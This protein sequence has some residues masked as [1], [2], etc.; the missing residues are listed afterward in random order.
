MQSDEPLSGFSTTVLC[1]F[2]HEL[3]PY[4]Y[5][6][7]LA[8]EGLPDLLRVPTGGGKTV[9]AVLPWLWRTTAFPEVTPR[10]LVY[11]LPLRTLVEQTANKV[12][13]W[14]SNLGLR[15]SPD[16][17]QSARE[18]K[19]VL[20]VL[21]GG[22]DRDDDLWQLEPGRRA[23]LIGTQDMILS[24]ALM[25]GY[26]E[27]RAKWPISYA[28]LHS[29]TQWVFD[30]TQLL[31]PALPT[32]AQLQGLRDTLGTAAPT[33]TMWM[34]A[35]LA[36][37]GLATVD[38]D[39]TALRTVELSAE[40]RVG[41]LA[42]RLNATRVVERLDLPTANKGYPSALAKELLERHRP[43][44][45]TIAVLN[46]V[47]RA[48]AVCAAV[49]K[50]DPQADVVLI[51]SRFRPAERGSL[52]TQ[53][54][55]DPP[56]AGRIVI[57]TQVLEAGV[58][59]SSRTL[60]S[61]AAPW[62]SIVQRAGRCNR[63]GEFE[64]A[65]LLWG[66]PPTGRAPAAPYTQED[67]DAA[68]EALIELQ[69][70]AVTSTELQ[71]R[72]VKQALELH[73]V[74]R[75]R[76]LLQL[77]DTMPDLTGADIDVS[78]WIREGDDG[79]VFVAWRD[80]SATGGRPGEDEPWPSREELCPAPLADVRKLTAS[81]SGAR[82]VWVRDR[83][84][85]VWRRANRRDVVPGV[86][87]LAD[88]SGGGYDPVLGWSMDSRAPA[89]TLTPVQPSHSVSENDSMGEDP[90]TSRGQ[91]WVSLTQHLEDV[92]NEVRKVAETTASP[93]MSPA[94]ITAAALAGRYHDLGK[95]HDVFQETLRTVGQSP[96]TGLLAKTPGGRIRH[97]RPYFRH[98]LVSALMLSH[99]S[100][101]LLDGQPERDLI[102]YL[103]AAHHGKVRLSVR[104]V[105]EESTAEPPLVLGVAEGDKTP[106]FSMA[107]SEQ[108]GQLTLST[109]SLR[110]GAEAG[111]S[112]TTR[113]VSL[114]DRPDLGP[115][116]L[117]FLEALVRIADMRVS[118]S[119]REG[120]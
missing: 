57:S 10:R 108:V 109:A 25:R 20:Q 101:R 42:R 98:E 27:A 34:S 119:Y 73:P 75:R 114:R 23:I 117:A 80:W 63:A 49:R 17:A 93:G 37:D 29:D 90:L 52:M 14:L 24:R 70:V 120:T 86:V 33:K 82:R 8:R 105:G 118:R 46:T 45:R 51:H 43:G 67:V 59:I 56:L 65:S 18:D 106:P 21:M 97:S 12:A 69:S 71:Q 100:C 1:A 32:S 3:A 115:F 11:V 79:G 15:A 60:F 92:D 40:D 47:E 110:L 28:L 26:A 48:T 64:V 53:V 19:V 54:E 104:S 103:T 102:T 44:T 55:E 58:D 62:S 36:E 4:P 88:A 74:V 113:A 68:A 50:A 2:G 77:F 81:D 94:H 31:G 9:A 84:D 91:P 112:W 39:V 6:A 35:T 61:E 111:D 72:E 87:L 96:I 16:P 78:P 13:A 107:S 5:Q 85:G 95:C 66:L 22:A 41:D 89:P 83:I 116:R 7:R 99:P 30:E 76:D 38:H